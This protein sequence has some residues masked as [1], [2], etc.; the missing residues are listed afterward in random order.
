M[1]PVFSRIAPTR[2]YLDSQE[3]VRGRAAPALT[4][5]E[6]KQDPPVTV[7]WVWVVK[8]EGEHN[9]IDEEVAKLF[10]KNLL[11][12]PDDQ[13]HLLQEKDQENQQQNQNPQ[14]RP[15]VPMINKFVWKGSAEELL[16]NDQAEYWKIVSYGKPH[17][18]GDVKLYDPKIVVMNYF[19]DDL[20]DLAIT[21]FHTLKVE[22]LVGSFGE[23]PDGRD[24]AAESH[25]N[26]CALQIETKA[27]IE[28]VIFD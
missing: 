3:T 5:K 21:R 25:V 6:L 20:Y 13:K 18:A 19:G 10:E 23:L 26:I 16:D 4:E 17:S 8:Q 9:N 2:E 11:H 12:L 15:A 28:R 14:G 24:G 1:A 27:L 7:N 22:D